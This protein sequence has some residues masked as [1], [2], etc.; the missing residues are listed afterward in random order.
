MNAAKVG[1]GAAFAWIGAAVRLVRGDPALWLGL[2][3]VYFLIALA[4]TRIPFLGRLVLILLAPML[5]GGALRTAQEGPAAGAGAA[6]VASAPRSAK[7]RFHLTAWL[8][9]PARRLFLLFRADARLANLVFLGILTLGS[10][11]LVQ[12]LS[13]FIVGGSP[14]SGLGIP[15]AAPA[16]PT[17]LVGLAVVSALHLVLAMALLYSVH[18]TVLG[19]V[20]PAQALAESLRACVRNA[21]PLAL[22]LA[23]FFAPYLVVSVAF[24]VSR[25][26]GYPLLLL[27]GV[28]ALAVFVPATYYSY[29]ALYGKA[30]EP[31]PFPT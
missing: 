26:L 3:L 18:L 22:F 31:S 15:A 16:S 14:L 5:A 11:I 9:N 12:V 24:G 27:V 23:A 21:L 1:A 7:L 25:W 17:Q 20:A 4:L 19:G 30:A 10:V 6:P 28:A 8:F 2:A 13:H 29:R